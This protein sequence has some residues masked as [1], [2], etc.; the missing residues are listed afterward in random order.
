MADMP[1]DDDVDRLNEVGASMQ[2]ANGY[3][4]QLSAEIQKQSAGIIISAEAMQEMVNS[5]SKA[6]DELKK[7]TTAAERKVKLEEMSKAMST[8]TMAQ[9]IQMNAHKITQNKLSEKEK[10]MWS[11]A[12]DEGAMRN[13]MQS[14]YKNI[15]M[16]G[17]NILDQSIKKVGELGHAVSASGE[18]V[19][20]EGAAAAAA[21]GIAGAATSNVVDNA[22]KMLTSQVSTMGPGGI[23]GF[24]LE[25]TYRS[26]EYAAVGHRA[27]QVYDK[28][29]G[30]ADGFASR[31][32]SL[33]RGLEKSGVLQ[34]G[35]M[36]AVSAAFAD[37]GQ[38]AA[39]AST[40]IA[41]FGMMYK[42]KD[43][44]NEMVAG[45]DRLDMATIALDKHMELAA[46]T[47]ATWAGTLARDF[48]MS[49]ESSVEK[50][51]KYGMA[52][53]KA[54]LNMATFMQQ[55]MEAASS[56]RML[57]A[58]LEGVFEKQL[59]FHQSMKDK[60]FSNQFAGEY[61]AHGIKSAATGLG[62]M[63][64]GMSAVIGEKVGKYGSGLD[65]W[66]KMKSPLARGKDDQQDIG[67]MFK[68]MGDELRGISGNRSEQVAAGMSLYGMDVAGVE[69]LLDANNKIQADGSTSKEV[70]KEMN[71]AMRTEPQKTNDILLKLQ[72][73]NEAFSKA[74]V[75]LLAL[76]INGLKTIFEVGRATWYS[77]M[78]FYEELKGT[79]LFGGK[80]NYNKIKE[81]KL[82][83]ADAMNNVNNITTS[84]EKNVTGL[85]KELTT[86]FTLM[87]ETMTDYG[88]NSKNMGASKTVL[89]EIGR[90]QEH[91]DSNIRGDTVQSLQEHQDLLDMV[92]GKV[93]KGQEKK[94][95]VNLKKGQKASVT[96]DF[97]FDDNEAEN[98][99]Q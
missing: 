84:G 80:P 53:Q 97:T 6:G 77:A 23:I 86:A 12:R 39:T 69:A 72:Q 65:A 64:M 94:Q 21:R 13:K 46:G 55:S 49:M 47:T 4:Q 18:V 81:Y 36:Q 3:A 59:S 66:Y 54:G 98:F 42:N 11:K 67:K 20:K 35:D 68:I 5:I 93:K 74:S 89:G 95:S 60:G 24:L 43:G 85:V 2:N 1:S 28:V 31:M 25:G 70:L 99:G 58:N 56:L 87:G 33:Q 30:A 90:L 62:G 88:I 91:R 19:K 10:D 16:D 48:N 75:H 37:L 82:L 32:T 7:S 34:P 9:Q 52:A 45:T 22:K 41:D 79:S 27:A 96:L 71:K 38:T 29:G 83:S 78:Q 76:V 8:F 63:S 44:V 61:A 15:L 50:L 92:S 73:I 14:E 26:A 17:N 51:S 40:K 57:N